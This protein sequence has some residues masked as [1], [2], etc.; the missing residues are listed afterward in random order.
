MAHDVFATYLTCIS[1]LE[2]GEDEY[3]AGQVQHMLENCRDMACNLPA[4][5]PK[6]LTTATTNRFSD[7][8]EMIS[9]LPQIV[10]QWYN[11][12]NIPIYVFTPDAALTRMGAQVLEE[13]LSR[14][15]DA[16]RF[17]YVKSD[18]AIPLEENLAVCAIMLCPSRFH[19]QQLAELSQRFSVSAIIAL[20]LDEAEDLADAVRKNDIG[21]LG[22][23]LARWEIESAPV[24]K[25]KRLLELLNQL[26]AMAGGGQT[27]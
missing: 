23:L 16:A 25:K 10:R 12:N 20:D 13:G 2:K 21:Q 5:L 19:S 27:A 15:E 18:G 3:S 22:F 8:E 1:E 24:V 9:A 7:F 4:N 6:W 26:G 14:E 11:H 17:V